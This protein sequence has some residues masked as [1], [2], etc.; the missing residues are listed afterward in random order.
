MARNPPSPPVSGKKPP[1]ERELKF[2]VEGLD[3]VR[4][5]LIE[6]EGD[7]V[8]PGSFEDNWV[9]DRNN[10]L[11]NIGCVLRLRRDGRGAYVTYKGPRRIEGAVK[12]RV[13]HEFSVEG[14][15]VDQA[16]ALFEALGYRVMR[17]YQKVREEW[18][19]GGVSI[20]L[21]HTPIGDY[22]EFEGDRAEVLAKRCG[23]DL[24]KVEQR[25]YLRLYDDYLKDHPEAP[26]EMVF[27]EE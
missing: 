1:E 5:R 20:A 11:E 14:E 27:P 22:V 24:K 10:E 16:K 21:D 2:R 15:G 26:P 4:E 3:G 18:R 19:V 17:R 25:S 8:G 23:L 12:V 13:E 6:I 7:R 9:L